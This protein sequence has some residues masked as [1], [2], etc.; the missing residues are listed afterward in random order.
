MAG[1]PEEARLDPERVRRRLTFLLRRNESRPTRE[2]DSHLRHAQ[3]IGRA[4][5]LQRD[6]GCLALLLD[7]DALAKNL[8]RSAGETWAS[9]GLFGGYALLRL[10]KNKG[11]PE[12]FADDLDQVATLLRRSEAEADDPVAA[13]P[14]GVPQNA[15]DEL[16]YLTRSVN[17]K[18]QLLN[19]LQATTKTDGRTAAAL[20]QHVQ[21]RLER[22][23][24]GVVEGMRVSSYVR[25]LESV[26]SGELGLRERNSLMLL[27]LHRAEHLASAKEDVHH[28]ERALNPAFVVDL[29]L[30]FLCI[31]AAENRLVETFNELM[32][33]QSG[34]VSLPW[35]IAKRLVPP[36]PAPR[37]TYRY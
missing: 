1:I 22:E 3:D 18:R 32:A 26:A 35:K 16:H 9:V 14:P 4:G 33:E 15:R 10:S 20:R 2:D 24:F 17:S 23:S 5:T 34:L 37:D 31:H 7:E 29:D 12:S 6:A 30:L 8:L 19:L 21:R 36:D 11:W 27:I 25:L 13:E 28:W